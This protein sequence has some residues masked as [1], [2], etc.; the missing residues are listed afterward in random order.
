[1]SPWVFFFVV[2]SLPQTRSLPDLCP[3]TPVFNGHDSYAKTFG[4]VANRSLVLVW[5]LRPF[6]AGYF[7]VKISQSHGEFRGREEAVNSFFFF[8][9]YHQQLHTDDVSGQK[10]GRHE[11]FVRPRVTITCKTQ[12]DKTY[13]CVNVVGDELSSSK[14]VSLLKP[15]LTLFDV[16]ASEGC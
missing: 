15:F 12:R 14:N 11:Q 6:T 9:W 4:N 3:F 1:M 13:S 16:L 5:L 2:T 10:K 7:A 8:F